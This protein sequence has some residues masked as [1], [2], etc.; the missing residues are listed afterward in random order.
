MF[1]YKEL[2]Q[3]ERIKEAT[4]EAKR[5]ADAKKAE[6]KRKADEIKRKKVMESIKKNPITMYCMQNVDRLNIEIPFKFNG[7]KIYYDF[8]WGFSTS[9]EINKEL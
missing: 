9:F 4:E 5:I 8:I 7:V 2:E 1:I 6:E 3:N